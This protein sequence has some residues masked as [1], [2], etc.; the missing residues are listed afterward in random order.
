MN[1]VF[2]SAFINSKNRLE[3]GVPLRNGPPPSLAVN[4]QGK[5]QQGFCAV[6]GC[7]LKV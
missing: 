1:F 2:G 5:F 4:F 7:R 3:A 6:T